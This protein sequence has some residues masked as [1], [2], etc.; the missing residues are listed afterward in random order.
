MVYA[1]VDMADRSGF[2]RVSSEGPGTPLFVY[3][4]ST[5]L[6]ASTLELQ[7]SDIGYLLEE[8]RSQDSVSARVPLRELTEIIE[9]ATSAPACNQRGEDYEEPLLWMHVSP[10]RLAFTVEWE[11]MGPATYSVAAQCAGSVGIAVSP[12]HLREFCRAAKVDEVL[13]RLPLEEGGTLVFEAGDWLAGTLPTPTG[14]E[15]YRPKV[16]QD[17]SSLYGPQATLRDKDG[18]YC[19]PR[20]RTP[21]YARLAND[22]PRL[23]IFAVA[24]SGVPLTFELLTELND[25][26]T[27]IGF[28]RCFWIDDQV[29]VEAESLIEAVRTDLVSELYRSVDLVAADIAPMLASMFGGVA[30][31]DAPGGS[32]W[33]WERYTETLVSVEVS[34]GEWVDL[35]GPASVERLP[36]GEPLHVMTAWDP[37]GHSAPAEVN[38]RAQGSLVAELWSTGCSVAR[39]RGRRPDGSH[40]DEAVAVFGLDRAAARSLGARYGQNTLFEIDSTSISLV[41][42][43]SERISSMSR[44]GQL[45]FDL[46]NGQRDRTD[47]ETDS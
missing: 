47:P 39:A 29:L 34:P 20:G 30:G 33:F 26:N 23:Q 12:L 42:C 19:L 40:V 32:E 9:I 2:L 15:R 14:V 27:R 18:D 28:V 1:A 4:G 5:L 7:P 35:N 44:F 17:L 36:M 10:D 38:E 41:A 31:P 43:D 45:T 24:L 46:P 37:G 22:P 8:A 3:D 6:E 13:L 16:E 21:V 25:L 11:G